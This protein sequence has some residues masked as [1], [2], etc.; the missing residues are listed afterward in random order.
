MQER[1]VQG[2][3]VLDGASDEQLPVDILHNLV[4]MECALAPG[5]PSTTEPATSLSLFSGCA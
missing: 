2:F 5:V 3:L 4:E 1:M